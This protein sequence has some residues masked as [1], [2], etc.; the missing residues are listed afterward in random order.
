MSLLV[1]RRGRQDVWLKALSS[2][3]GLRGVRLRDLNHPQFALAGIFAG[4]F[5]GWLYSYA[6]TG[7]GARGSRSHLFQQELID[8]VESPVEAT[9]EEKTTALR[10]KSIDL[11]I[12]NNVVMV[13]G[14]EVFRAPEG[15]A[16]T[17]RS[18]EDGSVSI[19]CNGVQVW[20]PV[21]V[22]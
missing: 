17:T 22:S 10:A 3:K 19:F 1:Y 5:G 6:L 12:R 13:N 7:F 4:S 18:A 16:V 2:R 15:A 21:P 8:E 20:P 9:K 14:Q 11:T